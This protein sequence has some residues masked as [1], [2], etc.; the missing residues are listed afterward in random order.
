V[1]ARQ[2]D[3]ETQ[4]RLRVWCDESKDQ[5]AIDGSMCGREYGIKNKTNLEALKMINDFVW[6]KEQFDGR[7]SKN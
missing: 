6:L 1:I 3:A 5:Y 2:Q 7:Y 4:E